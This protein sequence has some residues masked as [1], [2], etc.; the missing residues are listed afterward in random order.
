MTNLRQI[1]HGS[2]LRVINLIATS[3]VGFLM[4]PFLVHHLGDRSYGYWTLAGAILG[5]YG[6]LDFGI[7]SAVQFFVAKA[8]GEDDPREAN[9][10]VAT[11]FFTF[12][13]I[14]AFLL[15]VTIA[16]ATFASV[17]VKEASQEPVF[18]AVVLIMG[19][20]FAIGFP[21]R[22]FVGALCAHMRWDLLAQFGLGA[23]LLRTILIVLAVTRGGGLISLAAISVVTDT[24]MYLGYFLVLRRVQAPLVLSPFLVTGST[25][26]RILG[27]SFFTFIAKL[28]DQLRFY[29]DALVIGAFVAVSAITHYA[30]ASRLAL[31]FL[32]LMVA[33]MGLLSPWF[34]HMLGKD[35]HAGIKRVFVFGTKISA[36]IATIVASLMLVYGRPLIKGWVGESYQDAYIPLFLLTAAIFV[37]VAQSPSVS[38]LYGVYRHKFL[39]YEALAEGITNAILSIALARKYGVVGVA[40]GTAI[41]LV[42]ARLFV[43]PVYVCRNIGLRLRDYYVGILGRAT[44][45]PVIAIL[46]PAFALNRLV[47]NPN[48]PEIAA[49]VAFQATIAAIAALIIV[50]G[51]QERGTILTSL[52]SALHW[53]VPQPTVALAEKPQVTLVLGPQEQ[54]TV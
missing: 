52:L 40:L 35:D 36:V 34:S 2:G 43:Q 5:Y 47:P 20:G 28:A 29:I 30:I 22:A 16:L 12:A 48:L 13:S 53:R 21:A 31:T 19:V 44:I 7:V 42:I 46:L 10:V 25:F 15:F 50:F 1:I 38:Y 33:V 17:F 32:E 18:R 39:A 11:S 49:L 41:P 6:I 14:G 51:R 37:D 3:L 26:K 9:R 54:E 27:Y 23:L 45:L 8:R 24:L 4:L